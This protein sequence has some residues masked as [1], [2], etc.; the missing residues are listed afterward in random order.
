MTDGEAPLAAAGQAEPAPPRIEIDGMSKRF[1]AL[2][3]L[4]RVSLT[5][6]SGSFHA[7]LGENGAGKSTLAKCLMGYHRADAGSVLFDHE[8]HTIHEPRDAHALGVGM[9]YQHFTLIPN[10]TVAENLILAQPKLSGIIRWARERARLEDFLRDKP[11]RV[12]LDR[13]INDLAAGEKQ[14]L[15]ILKQ[16]FLNCRVLILD[17]PTTV[18]TPGEADEILGLMSELTQDRLLSVLLITHKLR[19]VATFA[20]EVTVLRKGRRVGHG[21]LRELERG[22]LTEMMIGSRQLARAAERTGRHRASPSLE[23]RG[24]TVANDRGFS[25]VN[26]VN[27]TVHAGEIVGVAGISGNGQRELVEVL[28]GQREADAGTIL[29]EGEPYRATR[30]Q[31]RRHQVYLLPEE[32]LRNSCV[33]KMSVAEN[34]AFRSYDEAPLAIGGWLLNGRAITRAARGLIARYRIKTDGAGA[35]AEALS[36]GNVQRMVLARELSHEV[37]VL[38]AQNPCFGLDFAAVAEIRSQ[39]MDVRN[40]G[41]AVLLVSEDLD[42]LLELADRLVVVFEGAFVYEVAAASADARTIGSHMAG[43]N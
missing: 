2:L 6:E 28:A 26:E 4:D 20:Q 42:E 17:E 10:M 32:A 16:L 30:Q 31:I 29:V 1:G 3:A 39:I 41:G 33:A 38:I 13:L 12:D 36:G 9:V 35:P 24:L 14:K 7:L 21:L 22:D 40:R 15:E 37:R 27:L 43:H 18:L 8:L 34:L 19:E 23:L 11:F 5:L 25:A